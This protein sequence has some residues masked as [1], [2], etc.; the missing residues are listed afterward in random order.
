MTRSLGRSA[1]MAPAIAALFAALFPTVPLQ[2]QPQ[3]AAESA[4]AVLLEPVPTPPQPVVTV[5]AP[6]P[7]STVSDNASGG[8][9]A[10][11]GSGS[12]ESSTSGAQHATSL[13]APAPQPQTALQAKSENGVSYLCGGIGQEEAEQIKQR[14]RDYG[15]MLTFAARNGSYLA[16]V[17]VEI[18][19][20]K[21]IPLLNTTCDAPMMLV[22]LPQA[23]NYRVRAE[24]GG[25]TVTRMITKSVHAISS[26]QVR[27]IV[28]AW[29]AE[30][31]GIENGAM[32]GGGAP[33]A[34]SGTR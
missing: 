23:G 17:H 34:Q 32:S 6:E 16:N 14:A 22:D 5:P 24:A 20:A 19:D 27:T 7:P 11:A 26:G 15:L 1:G 9:R 13:P 29:P 2:A 10:P 18:D 25:Y 30:A 31:A 21:G 4:G 28:M 12:G 3:P 8:Y 33:P